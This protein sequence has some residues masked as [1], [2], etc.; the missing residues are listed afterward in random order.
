MCLT[1]VSWNTSLT[2][3]RLFSRLH[4][5]A[6]RS[7]CHAS[8]P[9]IT[10][11]R[12]TGRCFT[13]IWVTTTA[14][15]GWCWPAW[16]SSTSSWWNVPGSTCWMPGRCGERAACP[17]WT[18]PSHST[19]GASSRW[20]IGFIVYIF[21]TRFGPKRLFRRKKDLFTLTESCGTEQP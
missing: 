16:A 14:L 13:V 10:W 19:R 1:E 18:C 2:L 11:R 17:T 12:S 8:V 6:T 4:I 7:D 9:Q 3:C 5:E 20:P 21:C 15:R